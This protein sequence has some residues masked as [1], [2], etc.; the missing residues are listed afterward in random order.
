MM[1]ISWLEWAPLI[2]E[3]FEIVA[4]PL[5]HLAM[6]LTDKRTGNCAIGYRPRT[7]RNVSR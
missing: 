2:I 6:I 5:V 3:G 1:T 7:G 4:V